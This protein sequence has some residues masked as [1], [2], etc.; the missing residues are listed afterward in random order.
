MRDAPPRSIG[1][2]TSHDARPSRRQKKKPALD[3]TGKPDEQPAEGPPRRHGVAATAVLLRLVT[4]LR[5]QAMAFFPTL[6]LGSV[7]NGT[8]VVVH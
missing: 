7:T 3:E 5:H 2:P 1:C 4:A 6:L 8:M